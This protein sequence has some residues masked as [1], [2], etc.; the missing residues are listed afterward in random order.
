MVRTRS[1]SGSLD[2]ALQSESL[3]PRRISIVVFAIVF[4]VAAVLLLYDGVTTGNY[5][6]VALVLAA[7]LFVLTL[8]ASLSLRKPPPAGRQR[9]KS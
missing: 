9:P 5:L 1:S 2:L 7:Y 8:E 4:S 6:L 3:K